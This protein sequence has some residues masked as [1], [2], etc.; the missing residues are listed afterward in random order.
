VIGFLIYFNKMSFYI[1]QIVTHK[2]L[3]HQE[4]IIVAINFSNETLHFEGGAYTGME[5]CVSKEYADSVSTEDQMISRRDE[6]SS[7]EARRREG[8]AC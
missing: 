8:R 6:T 7:A 1:G 2:C 3:Y 4:R 5:N